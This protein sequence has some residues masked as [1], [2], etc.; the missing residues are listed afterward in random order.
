MQSEYIY[1]VTGNRMS[2]KEYE[3]A[4]RPDLIAAARAR[5]ETILGRARSTLPADV[6]AGIRARFPIHLKT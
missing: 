4:G 3:E 1:P 5:K 6:D 2:P